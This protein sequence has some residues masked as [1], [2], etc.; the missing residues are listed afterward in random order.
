MKSLA[1]N[2]TYYQRE[3]RLSN[4]PQRQNVRS[5]RSEVTEIWQ[6]IVAHWAAT[7]EPRVWQT[8]AQVGRD[9]WNAYDPMSHQT[10]REVSVQDLRVWL[11]ERHYQ[12]NFSINRTV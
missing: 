7:S 5:W 10:L 12:N 6:T 1:T 2:N 11:E 9:S 8:S 4:A 3:Q